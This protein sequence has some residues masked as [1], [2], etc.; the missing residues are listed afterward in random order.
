M[1]L[2]NFT[3]EGSKY[4]AAGDHGENPKTFTVIKVDDEIQSMSGNVLNYYEIY[5][6]DDILTKIRE[7]YP[8]CCITEP[9]GTIGSSVT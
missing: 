7:S 1:T 4:H 5:A 2:I 3:H 6:G 8:G 9:D